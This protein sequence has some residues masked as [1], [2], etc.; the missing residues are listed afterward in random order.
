VTLEDYWFQQRYDAE[1]LRTIE[2]MTTPVQCTK[3]GRVYDLQGVKVVA[4]Y[5]DCTVW[6]CPGCGITVDDR[7]VGWGDHHYREMSKYDT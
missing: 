7:P 3:C 2:G 4:R 1:L 6:E 5:A